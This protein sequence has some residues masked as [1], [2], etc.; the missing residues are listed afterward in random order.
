MA[1]QKNRQ[2]KRDNPP[3]ELDEHQLD[4]ASGGRKAGGEQ[5]DYGV[6][7]PVGSNT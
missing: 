1:D 6:A 4:Q 3:S 2:D 7:K 5:Q